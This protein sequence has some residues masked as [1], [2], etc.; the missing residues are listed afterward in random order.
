MSESTARAR[1]PSRS[2]GIA[3]ETASHVRV[4]VDG[5]ARLGHDTPR[6]LRDAGVNRDDLAD[7]DGRIPCGVVGA[8]VRGAIAEK[9][10][11]NLGTRIGAATP[12]GAFPLIDYLIVTTETVAHGLEQL[13]RYFR[14]LAV[15][16]TLRFD[17]AAELTRIVYVGPQNPFAYEFSIAL[18]VAHLREET[19]GRFS[20]EYVSFTHVPD[21][22]K[23]V[24][25]ILGCRVKTQA[26][27]NG[28]ALTSAVW[29]L[30]LRRRDTALKQLLERHAD[31]M[32]AR[33]PSVGGAALEVRRLLASRTAGGDTRIESVARALATSPR[34]LQ[35][36]LVA[37][38]TRYK[39]LLEAARREA[40]ERYLG[41]SSL[42]I[43]EVAY[44]L[45][46]SERAAFHRAFKQWTG[47]TPQHFREGR[48][49]VP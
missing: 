2:A 23:E 43:A 47:V 29:N 45:G 14:L 25:R 5:L 37:E 19:S 1:R 34:S 46:Y 12:I 11:P 6:L 41:D 20:A 18:L 22:V 32:I 40:A 33:L 28:L 35:R 36:K 30:P 17:Q 4:I 13:A 24:E 49:A 10:A 9:P 21:D 16:V 39:T 27:W 44:L 31:E 38:G 15:P 8:L 3:T 48:R 7:P 42:P 26:S